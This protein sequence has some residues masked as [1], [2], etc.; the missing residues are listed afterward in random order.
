MFAL[1]H[2]L[3]NAHT[4]T[5][6]SITDDCV[7]PLPL[8]LLTVDAKACR[9]ISQ[10]ILKNFPP[11]TL[12]Y[13]HRRPVLF[14]LL[15][16][17]RK[18]S[19]VVAPNLCLLVLCVSVF[20]SLF[21]YLFLLTVLSMFAPC[22]YAFW[23]SV[24]LSLY[25]SPT[26]SMLAFNINMMLFPMGLI[27]RRRFCCVSV[28]YYFYWQRNVFGVLFCLSFRTYAVFNSLSAELWIVLFEYIC[29]LR[30]DNNTMHKLVGYEQSLQA[31]TQLFVY[32]RQMSKGEGA[33][34][35]PFVARAI[36]F[37]SNSSKLTNIC[38]LPRNCH[39]FPLER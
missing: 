38:L 27:E 23:V 33:R 31:R 2:L 24:S 12:S 5:K 14:P 35:L 6:H 25:I 8:P 11:S 3:Q 7:R 36:H 1:L 9:E 4:H 21:D 34:L 17:R 30:T 19:T 22:L 26:P 16:R 15:F 32:R 37:R 28:L 39:R 20:R 13:P 18:C 29:Q 10:N